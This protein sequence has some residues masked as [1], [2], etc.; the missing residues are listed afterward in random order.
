MKGALCD[1]VVLHE[2]G[3]PIRALPAEDE[4]AGRDTPGLI[5]DPL[6]SP[7]SDRKA[8]PLKEGIHRAAKLN[9]PA[10]SLDRLGLQVEH[11]QAGVGTVGYAYRHG[12]T[13]RSGQSSRGHG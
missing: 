1:E 10:A 12:F 5:P 3:T 9:T 8:K 7:A 11:D 13:I 6:V 2:V 4:I